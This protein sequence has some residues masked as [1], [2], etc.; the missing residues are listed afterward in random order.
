MISLRG[1]HL[2]LVG[3]L[4]APLVIAG[5]VGLTALFFLP[6]LGL[7]KMFPRRSPAGIGNVRAWEAAATRSR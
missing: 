4:A 1:G 2:L 3:I 6:L 7:R 5:Y